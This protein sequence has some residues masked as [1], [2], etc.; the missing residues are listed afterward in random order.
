V[1][2]CYSAID[3]S[4]KLVKMGIITCSYGRYPQSNGRGR[5]TSWKAILVAFACCLPVGLSLLELTLLSPEL[6]FILMLSQQE[7]IE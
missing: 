3:T 1:I 7:P 5:V 2:F 4:L 6:K